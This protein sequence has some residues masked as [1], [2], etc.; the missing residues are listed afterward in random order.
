MVTYTVAS[1]RP[2][3]ATVTRAG[4]GHGM[5]V[6]VPNFALQIE[7]GDI[8]DIGFCHD[9]H[10]ECIM[11]GMCYHKAD[12]VCFISCGGLLF[13]IPSPLQEHESG[14]I[15]CSV[16]PARPAKMR[17]RDAVER[18]PTRGVERKAARRASG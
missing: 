7:E 2:L 6:D 4:L 9:A 16:H 8:L 13:F 14:Y 17:K 12:G 1:A 10:A 18:A 15:S 5:F 3:N 11:H